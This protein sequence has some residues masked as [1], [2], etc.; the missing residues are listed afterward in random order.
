MKGTASESE[1]QDFPISP[2]IGPPFFDDSLRAWV[3]SRHSDVL[4]AFHCPGLHPSG[5]NRKRPAKAPALEALQ[6]MRRETRE[7][8]SP[9]TLRVWRKAL[10]AAARVRVRSMPENEP[11]DLVGSYSRPLSLMLAAMVTGVGAQKSERLYDIAEPIS[12]SAAEPYDPVLKS[13]AKP[14]NAKLATHFQSGPEPLRSSGFVALAHTLPCLLANAWYALLQ[15]PSQWR[16]L[17]RRPGLAARAIE[18][19]LRCSELPRIL[20]RRAAWDMEFNGARIRKGQRIVLHVVAANRDPA[21]FAHPNQVDIQRR[22]IGQL[23]LGAGP[24]SC[25]GAG[26]IR[27]AAVS[28]LH[29]LLERFPRARLIETVKWKGGSGFRYPASLWVRF[30]SEQP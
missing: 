21:R 11:V 29:P 7:A 19:L 1:L 25:V 27:M 15:S 10:T 28:I 17:H 30:D 22:R 12:A 20:F 18:E 26:L 14:A 3:L 6:E 24:H 9:A 16:A 5:L 23:A 4:A 8:L 2:E 13:S